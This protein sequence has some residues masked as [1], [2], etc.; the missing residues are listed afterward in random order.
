MQATLQETFDKHYQSLRKCSLKSLCQ[1]SERFDQFSLQDAH[2]FL[3]YSKHF[4]T[5]ETVALWQQWLDQQQLS[6]KRSALFQ[7]EVVNQTENRPALHTALRQVV[8]DGDLVSLPPHIQHD[9]IQMQRQ[10]Q[11]MVE[12]VRSH[13]WLGATNKAITTIINIGI[14]GSDL[15]PRFVCDALRTAKKQPTT[16]HFTA[17]LDETELADVLA[18][19][20]AETTLLIVASKSFCTEET[21]TNFE[22]AKQWFMHHDIHNLQQHVIAI[23]AHP[24]RAI[25]QGV[26]PSAILP[27]WDFVGGRFS[28]WSAIGLPIALQ[29]GWDVFVQLLTGAYAMDRHFMRQPLAQNMPVILACL[30]VCYGRF[31]AVQTHAILPYAHRLDKLPDYLQQMQMESGGKSVSLLHQ[32]VD[33]PTQPIVWGGVETN[34]QHAFHQLLHQGTHC[35]PVDF[36]LPRDASIEMAAHCFAQSASLLTGKSVE[37]VEDNSFVAAHRQYAG[38]RP[39]SMI[40]LDA[41]NAQSL[42]ALLA[43]YEHEV[44]VKSVLWNINPFDQW[45]VEEGKRMASILKPA[46]Q[47]ND[48]TLEHIDLSTQQLIHDWRCYKPKDHT[49]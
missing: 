44:F 20:S 39:S 17:N 26:S 41:L 15:G 31:F 23:T 1:E 47:G 36:I 30:D 22:Q 37:S 16:V 29:F 9:I 6:T 49:H 46:L 11:Q 2:L 43:L 27:M 13:Q 48:A 28:L 7:G 21:L 25:T 38:N 19:C 42:G 24:E 8:A 32:V 18:Q 33:Y 14:G 3:D 12:T 35:V 40:L 45:G 10:M 34:G 5:A 4:V